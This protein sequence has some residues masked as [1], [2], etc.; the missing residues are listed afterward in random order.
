M[1][2]AALSNLLNMFQRVTSYFYLQA[3][4][5]LAI[6]FIVCTGDR[7]VLYYLPGYRKD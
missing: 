7:G 6:R 4:R 5:K 3:R 2:F 1:V